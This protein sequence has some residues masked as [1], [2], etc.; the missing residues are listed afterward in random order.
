VRV[1][2]AGGSAKV[3]PELVPALLAVVEADERMIGGITS[4]YCR[5]IMRLADVE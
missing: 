2:A 3:D 1:I 4:C 5:K